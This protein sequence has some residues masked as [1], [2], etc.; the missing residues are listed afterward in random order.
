MLGD[1][2]ARDQLLTELVVDEVVARYPPHLEPLR[3]LPLVD[4][5]EL[6]L[7]AAL[8]LER[9]PVA[10]V[11]RAG[12]RFGRDLVVDGPL[13][14]LEY[15]GRLQLG[16]DLAQLELERARVLVQVGV[17]HVEVPACPP[18]LLVVAVVVL[19][20]QLQVLED[21]EVARARVGQ[22]VADLHLLPGVVDG[23]RPDVAVAGVA[24]LRVG[25]R[26]GALVPYAQAV[27]GE[28]VVRVARAL[29]RVSPQ[30]KLIA[31]LGLAGVVGFA[32]KF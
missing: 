7:D 14:H 32:K 3:V 12:V 6:D 13:D 10:H 27:V 25:A 8:V 18:S 4:D 23:S 28:G 21:L 24:A 17:G 30:K 1:R 11:L 2:H 22:L 15:V 29:V 20:S 9:Q 16:A 26:A 19:Q 31:L 5:L